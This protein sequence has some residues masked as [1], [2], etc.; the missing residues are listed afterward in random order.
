MRHLYLGHDEKAAIA[1]HLVEVLTAL[2]LC[3]TNRA[4]EGCG[5]APATPHY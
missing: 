2:R 1:H 3:P 4:D 5:T